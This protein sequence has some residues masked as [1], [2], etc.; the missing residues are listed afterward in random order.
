MKCDEQIDRARRWYERLREITDGRK[1]GRS[2]EFAR[3]E[4]CAFFQNCYHVKDWIINDEALTISDKINVVEQF[5]NESPRL[6]LCADLCNATKHL[7]LERHRSG[8]HPAVTHADIG[9]DVSAEIQRVRFWVS[10]ASGTT[11]DALD[12]AAHCLSEWDRF[13]RLTP[14]DHRPL[15]ERRQQKRKAKCKH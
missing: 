8:Q 4:A 5:I 6:S 3:D 13:F 7:V 11:L 14:D 15:S 9:I 10:T 2:P 12:L 1:H